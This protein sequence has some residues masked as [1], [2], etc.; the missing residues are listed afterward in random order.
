MLLRHLLAEEL[1]VEPFSHQ[2][3]L[4]V[5]ERD[6]DRVD[7]ARLDLAPELVEASAR[8]R[9]YARLTCLAEGARNTRLTPA[10]DPWED[11]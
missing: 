3:A 11:T 1:G 8:R 4:H 7:R 9:S 5:R 2:A 10:G 6:D